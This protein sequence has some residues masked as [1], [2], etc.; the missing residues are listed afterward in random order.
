MIPLAALD[1]VVRQGLPQLK[2]DGMNGRR[3]AAILILL[4]ACG[5][6]WV[7]DRDPETVEPSVA[8]VWPGIAA[9]T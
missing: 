2:G 9:L 8:L 5:M 7:G 6:H 3:L 1:S 4:P